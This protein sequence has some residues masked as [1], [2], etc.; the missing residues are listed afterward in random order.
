MMSVSY[1]GFTLFF[2]LYISVARKSG[3]AGT[4]VDRHASNVCLRAKGEEEAL[5]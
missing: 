4:F 1:A 5:A 3:R 2:S